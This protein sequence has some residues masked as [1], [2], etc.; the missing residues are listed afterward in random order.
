MIEARKK[1]RQQRSQEMVERI[2]TAARDMLNEQEFK[3]LTT[4]AIAQKAGLSVGSL[5]QYFPNKEAILLELVQRWLAA[6]RP[7]SAFYA[8]KPRPENWTGFSRD[9]CAFTREIA[10]VYAQNRALLPTLEAMQSHPELRRIAKDHDRGIIETH[11][12]WFRNADPQLPADIASRLGMLV[13]ETGNICFTIALMRDD[14]VY[15]AIIDDVIIMNEALL[16]AH[17]RLPE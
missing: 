3:G 16:R 14:T 9:F 7:V 10:S 4:N 17:L 13:L 8:A 15:D 12:A 2:V 1:P 11:A 6:F 5:Y